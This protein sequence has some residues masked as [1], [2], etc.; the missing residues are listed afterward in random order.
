MVLI[1]HEDVQNILPH[2]DSFVISN[3][4]DKVKIN[5]AKHIAN[6]NNIGYETIDAF[7]FPAATTIKGYAIEFLKKH[8]VKNIDVLDN[9]NL[10]YIFANA[11][12]FRKTEEYEVY[13]EEQMQHWRK[14]STTANKNAE[15]EK[16]LRA[17]YAMN[18]IN[19][20][21]ESAH[22]KGLALDVTLLTKE[23]L[24]PNRTIVSAAR[25]NKGF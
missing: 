20:A 13:S 23:E 24:F 4:F 16:H 1:V 15:E 19:T 22:A 18:V 21:I 5:L 6:K 9:L 2:L 17:A 7:D 12:G 10:I 25:M 8:N 3:E 11:L 14:T